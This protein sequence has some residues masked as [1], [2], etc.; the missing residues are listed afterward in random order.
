MKM[1]WDM[2]CQA[3]FLAG[4]FMKKYSVLTGVMVL[5][6]MFMSVDHAV[7][8]TQKE[9]YVVG[10][11]YIEYLPHYTVKNGEYSGFA[12]EMFDLF[13]TWAG[14]RFEYRALPVN[15]LFSELVEKKIDFKYPDN[16]RWHVDIKKDRGVV[17][18]DI[19]EEYLAGAVVL[20]G[21]KG[22]GV[23]NVK[24]LGAIL[25]FTPLPFMPYINAG[26]MTIHPNQHFDS[27][28]K[29]AILGRL[30]AV[31]LD[32]NVASY[33]LREILQQP[34][35]LVFDPGLPYSKSFY[36][37]STIQHPGMIK[38]F[39]RFLVEKKGDINALK[40]KYF[41]KIDLSGY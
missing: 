6:F 24:A 1:N 34:D 41:D 4:S 22:L 26:K 33:Q 15:R 38:R 9:A 36:S 23:E 21:Q 7:A 16:P 19:V 2:V 39:N 14:I 32:I 10:V 27:L 11:E 20:P 18:S 3:I 8:D 5:I 13:C 35:A 17:Y 12:R 28:L 40:L 25:G 29:Q 37:L 30:D 31:Y